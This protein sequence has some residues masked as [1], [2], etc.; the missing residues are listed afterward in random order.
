MAVVPSPPA[1]PVSYRQAPQMD[2]GRLGSWCAGRTPRTGRAGQ[3]G[4][5]VHFHPAISPLRAGSRV[6][7]ESGIWL[8]SQDE[9]SRVLSCDSSPRCACGSASPSLL[10]QTLHAKAAGNPPW[11]Y[12][13]PVRSVETQLLGVL[14]GVLVLCH[15]ASEIAAASQ[16]LLGLLPPVKTTAGIFPKILQAEVGP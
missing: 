10:P 15:P 7:A 1:A 12:K 9:P 8:L 11:L 4:A 3:G 6:V 2:L 14:L 13:Q 5:G 16:E